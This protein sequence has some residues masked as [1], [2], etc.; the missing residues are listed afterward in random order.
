MKRIAAADN[1]SFG[2]GDRLPRIRA[3]VDGIEAVTELLEA[4]TH[5]FG[6][7][8]EAIAHGGERDEQ[9]TAHAAAEK[10]FDLRFGMIEIALPVVSGVA[11]QQ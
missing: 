4:L 9:H 8:V 5:G 6:E 1:D 7:L 11:Q 2:F 10:R 3:C